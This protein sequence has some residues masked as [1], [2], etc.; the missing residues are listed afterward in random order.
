MSEFGALKDGENLS[1]DYL[2]LALQGKEFYE[3]PKPRWESLHPIMALAELFAITGEQRYRTAFER[4][5]WSIRDNDRHNNGGFSSGE[6][7]TGNPFDPRPIETCCTIAWTALSVE[8]LRMTRHPL[9][10]DELELT[11]LNSILGMHHPSGRWATY[12]TP[13]DGI[14]M[15]SAHQIV[16]QARAGSPE[17]NCC[18]VNSARGFGMLSDWAV[19]SDENTVWLNYYGPGSISIPLPG[20]ETVTIH[21]E[22]SYPLDG[23]VR[24]SINPSSPLG[25][26]LNLRIPGWSRKTKVSINAEPQPA[27]QPGAYLPIQRLWQSGDTI[28][29]E[30]DFS[31]RVWH[32]ERECA[33]K[34]SIYRGPLLLAYDLRYNRHLAETSRAEHQTYGQDPWKDPGLDLHP[35]AFDLDSLDFTPAQWHDWLPPQLLLEVRLPDGRS[36]CLCDFASAGLTGT[37]YH[38]WLPIKK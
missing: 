33:G 8:M 13:S 37:P 28:K 19:I 35:P 21:Q 36:A 25:M 22:T 11:L 23:S 2:E 18:S 26:N 17:L 1:G 14:R 9:V 24:I 38:S 6:Q 34:A 3:M 10:A 4:I 31:P 15:A 7:A 32:G 29:L 20:G 30:F 12:N 5:W 16:F 27:P